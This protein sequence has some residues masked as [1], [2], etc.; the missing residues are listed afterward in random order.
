MLNWTFEVILWKLGEIFTVSGS[1]LDGQ[2]K[3][4]A[5]TVSCVLRSGHGEHRREHLE[6]PDP[7]LRRRGDRRLLHGDGGAGH[8]VRLGYR[9]D[10]GGG[11][12]RG[13]EGD[14]HAD[15]GIAKSFER[16]PGALE[17]RC[18]LLQPDT[19]HFLIVKKRKLEKTN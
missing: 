12:L 3:N 10:R 19:L 11:F 18:S 13:F 1:Q 14:H 7:G 8:L 16:L 17:H 5:V 9:R 6:D 4:K 2:V 15:G